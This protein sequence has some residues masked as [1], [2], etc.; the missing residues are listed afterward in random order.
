MHPA[1]CIVNEHFETILQRSKNSYRGE[2]EGSYKEFYEAHLRKR[3]VGLLAI[4]Q[5]LYRQAILLLQVSLRKKLFEDSQS[6]HLA[7][8]E[9]SEGIG[10]V[11][12][13]QKDIPQ[14]AS[15]L[16]LLHALYKLLRGPNDAFIVALSRHV[17][18][19]HFSG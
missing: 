14:H 13:V 11:G 2:D 6:P 5:R 15:Y 8:V 18:F 9:W 10:D 1:C 4:V 3:D 7:Q 12:E 16:W 19:L 17:L